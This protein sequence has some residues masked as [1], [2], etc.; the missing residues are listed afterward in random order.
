MPLLSRELR[1]LLSRRLR[2]LGSSTIRVGGYTYYWSDRSNDHPFQG[3]DI[4]IPS[5]LQSLVVKVTPVDEGIMVL[6]LKL[7][8]DFTSLIAVYAP[9]E[10]CK[11]D[12]KERFYAKF[13][14]VADSCP[15][16]DI[17]IVMG[18]FN[19]VYGCD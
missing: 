13:A 7:A 16:R 17:C 15:Q 11:F 12:V 5:R 1:W 8:F 14:S 19:A 9:T 4:A 18:D 3:V 10:V 6:R 2:R